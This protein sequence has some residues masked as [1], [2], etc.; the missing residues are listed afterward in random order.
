MNANEGLEVGYPIKPRAGFRGG[1]FAGIASDGFARPLVPGDHFVGRA[2]QNI[3]TDGPEV[4]VRVQTSGDC[5]V[6]IEGVTVKD[7]GRTVF[8]VDRNGGWDLTVTK[9]SKPHSELGF[10]IAPTTPNRAIIH[11]QTQR[12]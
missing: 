12:K 2:S 9:P 6:N 5:E 7:V 4:S 8:A 10:V 1:A 3:A 11:F